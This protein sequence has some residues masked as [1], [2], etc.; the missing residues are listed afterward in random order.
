MKILFFD[1]EC[2]SLNA[3]FGPLL[4]GVLKEPARKPI[5]YR[6]DTYGPIGSD[7][8]KLV[9]ALVA[10]LSTA[11]VLIA[12][13]GVRFDIPFLNSRALRWGL[14][15]LDA[16]RVI[17]PVLL[18]RKH[19]KNASNKLENLSLHLGTKHRKSPVDGRVWQSAM[20][21][22]STEAMDE[23]VAHCI[24]DV[25]VL[26]EVTEALKPFIGVIG[27]WGSA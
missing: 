9:A 1:L 11:T 5:T 16:K 27:P 25:Y 19:M 24:A 23:V 17:D 3:D 21:D 8:S 22:H 18:A 20:Y 7:D 13:N 6:L 15:T 2:A 12:H 4:C 14:P 26:E 10:E